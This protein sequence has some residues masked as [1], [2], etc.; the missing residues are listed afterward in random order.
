MSRAS[1]TRTFQAP[2]GMNDV[3]P[4]VQ[5]YW[6]KFFRISKELALYY[7]F[8]IIETPVLEFADLFEK[9]IGLNTDVVEHEMYA[10]KTK[11]GDFLEKA[12]RLLTP[13]S[14]K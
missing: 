9:G 3:L 1:K 11:G 7:G 13:R 6:E 14:F 4:N 10:F 12:I 8:E 5:K 2:K